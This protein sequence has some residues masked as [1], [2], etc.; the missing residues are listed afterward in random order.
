VDFRF[1]Y[2]RTP[3]DEHEKRGEE[4]RQTDTTRR[5]RGLAVGLSIPMSLVAGPVAGWLIGGWLDRELGTGYWMT[6]LILL[7][8]AASIFM[9]I[10][11]LAQLGRD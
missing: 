11:L 7:C 1:K 2:S 4:R 3:P 10:E 9:V 8:T 5:I 6:V